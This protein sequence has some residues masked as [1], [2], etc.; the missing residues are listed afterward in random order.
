MDSSQ[1]IWNHLW[2]KME[3]APVAVQEDHVDR[4][5]HTY[6]M[7][8]LRRNNEQAR[9]RLKPSLAQQ[10]YEP[11]QTRIGNPYLVAQYGVLSSIENC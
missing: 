5:P 2:A 6:G 9:S 10:S 1:S 3:D 11:A 8:S 4:E 7:D